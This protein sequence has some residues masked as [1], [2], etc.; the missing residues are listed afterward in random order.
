MNKEEQKS[1][2][3]K[4]LEAFAQELTTSIEGQK[5][6]FILIGIEEN[7]VEGEEGK[8]SRNAVIGVTGNGGLLA[9]GLAQFITQ[10]ETGEIHNNALKRAFVSR[11]F[12]KLLG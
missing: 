10:P 12:D 1:E 2:F 6:G 7:K 5:K 3:A 8:T 11:M 4:K 9:E